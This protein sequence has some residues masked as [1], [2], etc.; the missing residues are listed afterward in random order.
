VKAVRRL[1]RPFVPWP[2]L[3]WYRRRRGLRLDAANAA[4]G[5]G[6]VFDHIYLNERWGT[7]GSRFYSGG[8]SDDAVAGPYVAAVLAIIG[9]H[10]VRS[11]TDLGC[12]DFRVG[13]RIVPHVD[14]YVGVDVAPSLVSWLNETHARPGH[15]EFRCADLTRD[16][17]P[18]AD[19]YLVREV[20]QH[21]NN[22]Q[23]GGFMASLPRSGWLIVTEHQPDDADMVA[24]NLDQLAG[25]RIR[26]ARGSGVYL[27]RPPFSLG[28]FRGVIV[29]VPLQDDSG[30][31]DGVVRSF[32][33]RLGPD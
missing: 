11:V 21:L 22:A 29:E 9:E 6:A 32:L 27:E 19:L 17:L 16:P 15:V 12:G 4:L 33:F 20:L 1:L 23:I 7:D 10:G 24:A 31:P 2:I 25:V 5:L 18:P 28:G 3:Q 13:A 8:G 30:K 26:L 14:R